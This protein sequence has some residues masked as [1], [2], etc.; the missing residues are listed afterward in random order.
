MRQPT[1][2][3]IVDDHPVFRS[4]L[5]Q[6]LA[7]EP[8]LHVIGEAENGREAIEKALAGAPDV[9]LMDLDMPVMDGFAATEELVRQGFVGSVLVLS[10]H[11]DDA[12]LYRALRSGA[13]GYLTK[14]NSINEIAVAIERT[15]AGDAPLDPTLLEQIV[16]NFR[17]RF[18]ATPGLSR[19][20]EPLDS[21]F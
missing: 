14:T 16:A 4:G 17:E 10:M 6:L 7:L 11:H 12:V 5:R 20:G 21:S 19:P 8:G 3:L 9:I 1:R 2:V 15:M 18:G 13:R